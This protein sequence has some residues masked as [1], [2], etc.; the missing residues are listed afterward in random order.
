MYR[1][2]LRGNASVREWELENI[3]DY[4]KATVGASA[5]LAA[6]RRNL[7]AELAFWLGEQFVSVLNDYEK[8]FDTLDLSV[9]MEGAVYTDFPL[10]PLAFSL[11]Q[12]MAPR[13]LQANGGSSKPIQ[14]NKSILFANIASHLLEFMVRETTNI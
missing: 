3:Q 13:V 12:H 4:D 7:R 9:L 14:I 1:M 8:N 10:A 5:L 2:T 6:L 11:Q